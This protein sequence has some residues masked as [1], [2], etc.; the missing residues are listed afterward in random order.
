MSEQ[1]KRAFTT[2]DDMVSFYA[3][4]TNVAVTARDVVIL[5]MYETIPPYPVD[6]ES[7]TDESETKTVLTRMRACVMM[8]PRHAIKIAELIT[9]SVAKLESEDVSKDESDARA[10]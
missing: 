4:I 8:S 2:A 6:E 10:S 9:K 5:S 7:A 3:D 1:L